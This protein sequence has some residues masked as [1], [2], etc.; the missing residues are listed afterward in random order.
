MIELYGILD[1]LTRDWTDGLL[2]NIFREINKPLD[3]DKDERKY[4]LFDG[5][6]DA[7]WIENM[8]SV[9]DDNKILT[10]ANQERIKLQKH[11]ALLFEVSYILIENVDCL[12][13]YTFVIL[14]VGDLQYASPATVSR[15][16]MVYVD[17]KNLGY[18]PFMDKWINSRREDERE[19]FAAMCE[20]Y[21]HGSL[22]LIID[23]MMDMQQVV[24]LKMIIPQTG[25]NMVNRFHPSHQYTCSILSLAVFQVTQL[26]YMLDGLYPVKKEDERAKTVVESSS[27]AEEE[28]EIAV[29]LAQRNELLEAIYI[30]S[31][32]CS[33]GAS[34]IIDCRLVFDDY[35]KKICGLMLTDDTHEKPATCRKPR[36]SNAHKSN[37]T[38]FLQPLKDIFSH[39]VH[40]DILSI[41]L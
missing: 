27:N 31:C 2:S 38:S 7:L 3:S 34:L 41:S 22:R 16:G 19:F 35:I 1:P 18:Q 11:S 10:L 21:V 28:E 40:S 25:L 24:P 9:M 20:K 37:V 6:V 5:D 12:T 14:Q 13:N 33:F 23:G 15:A 29:Q 8:N 4:I 30:Q 36:R 39:R 32:Y 26:C 17:P